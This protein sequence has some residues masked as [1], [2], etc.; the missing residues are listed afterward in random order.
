MAI[1]LGAMTLP[2]GLVWIDEFDWTPVQQSS[3][4]SLSGALMVH[5]ATKL[6]GRPIT[7]SGQ[8]DGAHHTAWISRT[9][10]LTLKSALDMAGATFT[11]TLHDARS[12]T[13]AANGPI[14]ATPLPVYRSLLPA[15]PDDDFWYRLIEIP[16]I[17]V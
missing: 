8:T 10:L 6:A 13:V 2:A 15:D 3:E 16:L 9:H 17:E 14:K 1:T 12:F 4:Y 5:S 7:L 11:L